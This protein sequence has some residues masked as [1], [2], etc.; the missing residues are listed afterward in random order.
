MLREPEPSFVV[1][2]QELDYR[3]E[4]LLKDGPVT[5]YI[6]PLRVSRSGI[7]IREFM[8]SAKGTL[9]TESQAVLVRW[10][11]EARRSMPFTDSE[12]ERILGQGGS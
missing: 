2:R 12:R 7:A 3:N 8:K 4:I 10:D 9:H 1:V 5:V 6:E 11:R